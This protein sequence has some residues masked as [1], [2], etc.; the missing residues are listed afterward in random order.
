MIEREI[1]NR[2][3]TNPKVMAGKPIIKGTRLT[4]E[5]ILNLLAHGATVAEILEEYE[6]LAEADIRA[7]LLFASRSL[8]S[9]SFMPLIAEIA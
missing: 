8:E 1:L 5:Y 2:I 4:V 6:G 3:T 9:T 7:C